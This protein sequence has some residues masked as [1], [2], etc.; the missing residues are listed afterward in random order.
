[1]EI[2]WGDADDLMT[3]AYA[4]RMLD[5]LPA[6]R[7]ATVAD[8]GHVPQRECPDRLLAVLLEALAQPPPAAAAEAR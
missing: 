7:M 2:V 3:V 4:R 1:V 6:A 5:G 8:C